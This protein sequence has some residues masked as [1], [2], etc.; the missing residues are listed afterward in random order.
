[1]RR[2]VRY[3]IT[4]LSLTLLGFFLSFIAVLHVLILS[5][6]MILAGFIL[7]VRGLILYH[8]IILEERV[9]RAKRETS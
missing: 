1:M 8:E 5:L 3:I 6:A 7:T 2:W 9:K 4:G